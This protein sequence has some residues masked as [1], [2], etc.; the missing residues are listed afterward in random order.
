M[1]TWNRQFYLDDIDL[2]AMTDFYSHYIDLGPE[3][4]P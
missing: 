1:V 2:T 4:I 3:F